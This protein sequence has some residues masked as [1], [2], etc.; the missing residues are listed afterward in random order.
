LVIPAGASAQ[1]KLNNFPLY[2]PESVAEDAEYYY[3]SDLGKELNPVGKDG[4]GIIWKI[5]KSGAAGDSVFAR[6]LNAPKGTVILNGILYTADVDKVSAFVIYS[7]EKKF[8]I[9]LSATKTEF[10]NDITVKDD[11]TLFVS[12]TDINKIYIIHLADKPSYEELVLDEILHGPNG[13]FYHKTRNRLYAACFGSNNQPN[14]EAGF[15]EMSRDLKTFTKISDRQGLY[16]GLAVSDNN[17]IL[18]SDWV[19]FEKKGMILKVSA[20]NKKTDS[21]NQPPIGGPADFML[22]EKNEIILPAMLDSCLL[23]I[24]LE[25]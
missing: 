6:G 25:K 9:D 18:L 22:N 24:S 16:D 17:T 4:D 20:D 12:A 3:V 10:L 21:L 13:L 1:E 11:S 15:I 8:D 14:G 23:K 7:G 19:A 5:S 2:H